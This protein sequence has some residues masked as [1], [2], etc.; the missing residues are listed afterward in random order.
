MERQEAPETQEPGCGPHTMKQT[1]SP[2][3][4]WCPPAP[5]NRMPSAMHTEKKTAYISPRTHGNKYTGPM[6]GPE[7]FCNHLAENEIW[8]HHVWVC[9]FCLVNG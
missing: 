7:H 2:K 5:T 4:Q 8:R 9:D 6:W 3:Q 1:V